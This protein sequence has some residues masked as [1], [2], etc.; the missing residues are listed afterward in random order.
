MGHPVF[1]DYNIFNPGFMVNFLLVPDLL[2]FI[3][4][5]LQNNLSFFKDK[6]EHVIKIQGIPS[7]NSREFANLLKLLYT[8]V[9]AGLLKYFVQSF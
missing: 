9:K 6:L 8:Y 1:Y 7:E 2:G 5:I 3:A 4:T